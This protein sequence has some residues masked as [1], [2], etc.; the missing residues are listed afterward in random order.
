MT[1]KPFLDTNVIVYAF[2]RNDRRKSAVANRILDS[3][4]QI[5]WQVVQEFSHVALHRFATPMRPEDLA[6]FIELL[7]WPRCTV[8]PS[9]DL[10]REAVAISRTTQYRFYDS[11]IIAAAIASGATRIFTEDLQPHRVLGDLRIENPFV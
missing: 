4:W 6:E 9:V 2:D 11:L 8:L 10:Y 5:S 1:D 7:L 3:E